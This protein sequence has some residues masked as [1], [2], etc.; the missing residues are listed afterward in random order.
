MILRQH[1]GSA[2]DVMSVMAAREP[3]KAIYERGL[4]TI[5]SIGSQMLVWSRFAERCPKT[6]LESA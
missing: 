4:D 1:V 5:E 3:V 6:G 2:F